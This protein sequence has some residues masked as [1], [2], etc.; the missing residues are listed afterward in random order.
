MQKKIGPK[1]TKEIHKFGFRVAFQMDP[2][3]NN[4][5]CKNKHKL[6]PNTHLG[7][8]AWKCS[9]GWAYNGVTN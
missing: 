9:Y 6:I 1:I 7:V 5:S 4:I 3:L 8:Y 2:Y